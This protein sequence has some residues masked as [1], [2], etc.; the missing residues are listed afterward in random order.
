MDRTYFGERERER[1]RGERERGEGHVPFKTLTNYG[2]MGIAM[3]DMPAVDG[4]ASSSPKGL[5]LQLQVFSDGV[6]ET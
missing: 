6:T 3:E 5:L 4:Y 2:I 1:E